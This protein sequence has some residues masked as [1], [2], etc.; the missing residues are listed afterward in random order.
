M[1]RFIALFL[2]ALLASCSQQPSPSYE[3][4]ITFFVKNA[5][6]FDELRQYY[7][8]VADER[9]LSRYA[10]N[11]EYNK[12]A[13]RIGELDSL[14]EKVNGRVVHYDKANN[15]E[16]ILG[17]EIYRKRIVNAGF[18]YYYSYNL[19]EPDCL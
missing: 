12:S 10:I 16:C 17:I 13:P 8:E 5:Q 2:V 19:Q 6:S 4:M 14:I 1:R 7:C 3:D 15:G 18:E 9:G 11:D